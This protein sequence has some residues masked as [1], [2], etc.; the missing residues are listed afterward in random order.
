MCKSRARVICMCA[1]PRVIMCFQHIR[2]HTGGRS[3]HRLRCFEAYQNQ[4]LARLAIKTI[5]SIKQHVIS[6]TVKK[7]QGQAKNQIK[8]LSLTIESKQR[9]QIIKEIIQSNQKVQ[10]KPQG[11]LQY[12]AEFKKGVYQM[13]EQIIKD[14]IETHC[15]NLMNIFALDCSVKNKVRVLYKENVS[16]FA[17][18]VELFIGNG[19]YEF[20]DLM[21][22]YYNKSLK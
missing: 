15:V 9:I 5:N 11:S 22:I 19:V 2:N 1:N 7:F 17:G 18:I 16:R 14:V 20:H 13:R 10:L 8:E 12:L 21:K 3:F 6:A 4:R